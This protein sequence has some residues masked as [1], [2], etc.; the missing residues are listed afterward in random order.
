M[1]KSL[2][3]S[4]L[5]DPFSS[6]NFISVLVKHI[7]PPEESQRNIFDQVRV[8]QRHHHRHDRGEEHALAGVAS[9]YGVFRAPPH[10]AAGGNR[11]AVLA[12]MAMTKVNVKSRVSEQGSTLDG[13]TSKRTPPPKS[14]TEVT[15]LMR[16][17]SSGLL[18]RKKNCSNQDSILLEDYKNQSDA[19][20][21]S[22]E[23]YTPDRQ[24]YHRPLRTVTDVLT[25][26]EFC[27]SQGALF[28]ISVYTYCNMSLYFIFASILVS[29][30]Q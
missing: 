3:F 16:R 1:L 22:D 25:L 30:S 15:R 21:N 9:P 12:D 24:F 8:K 11:L 14:L 27:V 19:D 5:S 23:H 20:L 29:P 2:L 26:P 18:L 10:L 28:I 13:T 6:K 17:K 7:D 4:S